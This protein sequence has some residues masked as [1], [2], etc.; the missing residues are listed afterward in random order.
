[1]D[2]KISVLTVV[3]HAYENPTNLINSFSSQ[4]Y[5]EKELLMMTN[6]GLNV[7]DDVKV[8]QPQHSFRENIDFLVSQASGDYII[9]MHP[10]EFFSEN[11]ALEELI[12]KCLAENA[13]ALVF[14]YMKLEDGKF[15]F[16]HY[17]DDVRIR[18]LYPSSVP[19]LMNR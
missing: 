17:G 3:N 6:Q 10:N 18:P 16:H 11:T 12:S 4:S 7:C 13:D 19:I 14:S 9:F 1:M 5:P 15:Y 2:Y 8:F